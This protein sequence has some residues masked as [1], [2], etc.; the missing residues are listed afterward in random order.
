M[1]AAA[2]AGTVSAHAHPS[3]S[4]TPAPGAARLASRYA[5][6]LTVET[7]LMAMTG[8][9]TRRL[10]WVAA[11]NRWAIDSVTSASRTTPASSRTGATTEAMTAGSAAR[12]RNAFGGQSASQSAHGVWAG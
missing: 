11:R 12:M 10:N 2:I 8:P 4:T 6:K 5:D 9:I 7:A 3:S 1:N